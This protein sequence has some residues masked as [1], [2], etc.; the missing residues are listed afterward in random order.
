MLFVVQQLLFKAAREF[1]HQYKECIKADNSENRLNKEFKD[2]FIKEMLRFNGKVA[3][4]D[5]AESISDATSEGM[6]S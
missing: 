6:K 1:E 3:V 5:G 4:G 2:R